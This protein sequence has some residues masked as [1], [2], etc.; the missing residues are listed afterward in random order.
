M[1]ARMAFAAAILF[2]FAGFSFA[3]D[4]V[5]KEIAKFNGT[6]QLVSAERDGKKVPEDVVKKIH[7]VIKDGK[8][9]VYFGD[10][11]VVKDVHFTVD[12]SKTPKRVTDTLPDGKKIN[13]IYEMTGDTLKSCVAEPDKD[14]PTEFSAKQ[15]TGQ[16]L[17]IFKRIKK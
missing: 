7:V 8:H 17:R 13:G 12:P 6:W 16:T 15:G 14:F 4:A 9:T 10:D 5:Q 2:A 1:T 3:D 11:P